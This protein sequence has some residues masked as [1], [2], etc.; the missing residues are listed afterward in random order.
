MIGPWNAEVVYLN[1]LN[2]LM[3]RNIKMA[4]SKDTKKETKKEPAK[5]PK[6]KKQEK[7]EKK[8]K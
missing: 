4:K 8:N 2:V 6:E 1:Y 3:W 5:S 7:R